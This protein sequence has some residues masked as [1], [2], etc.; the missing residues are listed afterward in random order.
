[1]K[2]N[3]NV[4][5]I[6]N[7]V[8][9][10][11][12]RKEHVSL[13]HAWMVRLPT[14]V[15]APSLATVCRLVCGCLQHSLSCALTPAVP[16]ARSGSARSNSVRTSDLTGK[17]PSQPGLLC[18]RTPSVKPAV[19]EEYDMQLS[20]SEDADSENTQCPSHCTKPFTSDMEAAANVFCSRVYIYSIRP[21][22]TEHTGNR[23]PWRRYDVSLGSNGA[24][25]HASSLAISML[26]SQQCT[27]CCFWV[28]YVH[29][30]LGCVR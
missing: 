14:P 2:I 7:S 23:S 1:M 10:V 24:Q 8:T 15:A 22:T 21:H 18:S 5:I 3:S 16:A 30:T 6:G 17:P 19:Q 13:Y 12:Y 20:W 25:P 11:P 26:M 29:I 27:H 9:L 28:S 4:Q